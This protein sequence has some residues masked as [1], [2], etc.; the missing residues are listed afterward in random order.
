MP[1]IRSIATTALL[2]LVAI[3]GF[4]QAKAAAP[5]AIVNE[6]LAAWNLCAAAVSGAEARHRIPR[7]L[8]HAISLVESGRWHARRKKTIAWPWTVY[9]RGKGRF[10]PTKRAAIAA[11]EALRRQGVANIDVGCMQVNLM[12]HPKAFAS[13]HAAFDPARNTAYA[14]TFLARL[15]RR[16]NSW[17]VAVQHYHSATPANRIPYQKK[18]YAAWRK[19]ASGKQTA[20]APR[21]IGKNTPRVAPDRRTGKQALVNRRNRVPARGASRKS[22]R[23][24]KRASFLAQWPPRSARA[25][26]RAQLRARA[27]ALN[28]Q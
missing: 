27:W 23:S 15:K 26:R 18:V 25:Q 24:R 13:L 6:R 7:R 9:A 20:Q 1:S 14:G 28:P 2:C 22:S 5:G 21:R 4:G 10:F 19:T 11:V 16:H 17:P 12:Y 3:P 8:L